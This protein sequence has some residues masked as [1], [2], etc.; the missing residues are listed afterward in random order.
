M[1]NILAVLTPLLRFQEETE[2]SFS[3]V[4]REGS[5]SKVKVLVSRFS[6]FSASIN[7]LKL[8]R[9]FAQYPSSS[10]L[11]H[12]ISYTNL[13]QIYSRNEIHR[14]HNP[15]LCCFFLEQHALEK[16]KKKKRSTGNTGEKGR[17]SE[18]GFEMDSGDRKLKSSGAEGV[19]VMIEAAVTVELAKSRV[20]E[21]NR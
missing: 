19:G 2:L 10:T 5:R 7:P 12:P 9:E 20:R 6:L 18:N 8:N 3:F 16:K 11:F 4:K 1:R 14:R 17:G 21:S 15:F 13:S